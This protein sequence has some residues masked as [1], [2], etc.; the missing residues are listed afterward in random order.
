M[1]KKA[2]I[3]RAKKAN[4]ERNWIEICFIKS[5]FRE[6]EIFICKLCHAR[7]SLIECHLILCHFYTKEELIE[8][9]NNNQ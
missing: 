1:N 8:L 3:E 5:K 2:R 6:K 4:R 9:R 7:T